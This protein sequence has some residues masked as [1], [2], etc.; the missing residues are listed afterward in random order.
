MA[1]LI[2]LAQLDGAC[3]LHEPAAAVNYISRKGPRVATR[4]G[5]AQHDGMYDLHEPAAAVNCKFRKGQEW[6]LALGLLSA[7]GRA[8]VALDDGWKVA[9]ALDLNESPA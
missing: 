8:V 7:T 1:T 4:T 2:G 6:Q 9:V 5:R 3:D